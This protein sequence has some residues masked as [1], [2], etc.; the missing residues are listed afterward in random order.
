M[1][2]ISDL[3]WVNTIRAPPTVYPIIFLDGCLIT[4]YQLA[5]T[6]RKSQHENSLCRF[7]FTDLISLA[8]QTM[9]CIAS[10][11]SLDYSQ[12]N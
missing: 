2:K 10:Q 11:S 8:V 6:T 7:D 9:M 12:L 5:P 1:Q 4:I 3:R